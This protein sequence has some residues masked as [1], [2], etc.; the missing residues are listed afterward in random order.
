[1]HYDYILMNVLG[2]AHINQIAKTPQ[3]V[4][5]KDKGPALTEPTRRQKGRRGR[6]D[7]EGQEERC[8]R[9]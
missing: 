1:M 5:Q 3:A 2:A 6:A 8:S 7:G 4:G 9:R